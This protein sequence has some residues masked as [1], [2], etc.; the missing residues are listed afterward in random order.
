DYGVPQKRW[1]VF[2]LGSRDGEDIDIPVATHG[3]PTLRPLG[4]GRRQWVTLRQTIKG[5]E[6]ENWYEF[7]EGR[8]ELLRQL[9]AGANWR[10]LP[11]RLHRRALGAELE[12]W[13]GRTGFCRR[14]DWGE[15]S[16]TL[17]TDP[18]GRATTLCHPSKER[19]LSIEEYAALQQF[20]KAWKFVG[21]LNQQYM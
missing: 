13:G 19:P 21:S 6:S 16:P 12:Y 11:V 18:C 17:T 8:L 2:F 1:R 10:Q 14:L 7:P 4:N 5:V 9:K 3:D 20:P 15:P